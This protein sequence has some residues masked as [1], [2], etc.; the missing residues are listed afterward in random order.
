MTIILSEATVFNLISRHRHSFIII[1]TS[2]TSYS[3]QSIYFIS[4]YTTQEGTVFHENDGVNHA[5]G[6]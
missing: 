2:T 4:S 6:Y 3:E 1:I 5:I